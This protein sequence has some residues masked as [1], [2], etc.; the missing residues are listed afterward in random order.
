MQLFPS[1]FW[2]LM[3]IDRAAAMGV[4]SAAIDSNIV[5]SNFKNELRWKEMVVLPGREDTDG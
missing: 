5:I 1:R 2:M 3:W 4:G